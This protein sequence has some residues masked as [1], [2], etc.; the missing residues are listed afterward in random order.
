MMKN[1][2]RLMYGCIGSLFLNGIV[3]YRGKMKSCQVGGKKIMRK[4]RDDL[5]VLPGE[6]REERAAI[7]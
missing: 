6:V 7:L 5:Y 4:M 1:V 3:Y 2:N